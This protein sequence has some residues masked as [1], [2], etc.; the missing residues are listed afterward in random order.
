MA[1]GGAVSSGP[2]KPVP[3]ELTRP[4]CY[5]LTFVAVLVSLISFI[6]LLVNVGKMPPPPLTA[7]SVMCQDDILSTIQFRL[8]GVYYS[9]ADGKNAY[10]P[11]RL[12]N[13]S[14]I[15]VDKPLKYDPEV[16]KK[17]FDSLP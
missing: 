5:G 17:N 12:Y 10:R 15:F 16:V 11:D 1:G 8:R 14:K 13:D 6:I 2:S 4:Q 9:T 3:T 7:C